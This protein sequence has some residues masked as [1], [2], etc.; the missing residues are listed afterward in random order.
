[1]STRTATKHVVWHC[2][3]TKPGL[4]IGAREIREWHLAKGWA[5]IGY[6]LVIRRDG[7]IEPGRAM[8]DIGAHVAGH[9][10]NSIGVC[11]VGGLDDQGR[12][13]A[14]RPDLFTAQQ[15][16]SARIVYQFLRRMYPH[17][18]HVG[19]RDLS[20]DKD[21]D[22]KITQGEWLKTCPTFSVAEELVKL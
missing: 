20:P 21:M 8:D 13:F 15:W 2:S 4:D 14:S 3:A 5:D 22:G 12:S 10:S 7:T 1:M 6:H 16:V 17:A 11:L 9:N 19:H 18:L